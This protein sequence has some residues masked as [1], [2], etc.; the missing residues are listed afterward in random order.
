MNN[1][2][3]VVMGS[4]LLG[5]LEV[6]DRS[7]ATVARL[8]VGHWPVTVGRALSADLV[9]DDG[10]IAAEHLRIDAP[11]AGHIVVD[12]LDT[13]NG[14]RHGKLWHPRGAQFDWNGDDE[15]SLGRLR[16]RLR[17]PDMPIAAEQALPQSPWKI[18]GVTVALL[19]AV[20]GL[21]LVQAWF[22]ATDT[23]KF[24]QT[25]IGLPS[26]V[27]AALGVWAGMWALATKLFTGH[28]QFWRHVR[29]AATFSLIEPLVS[30]SGYLLAFMFSLESLAR[31]NF[32]LSG[33]VLATGVFMHLVVISPQ[34]R[35]ALMAIM[36]AITILGIVAT[37]GSNWLQ[38]KRATN[39][40]YMAA[41][42]PPSWRV[43]STVPV[44]QF[45]HE[46]NS[47]RSRL[48]ERLQDH[49][50]TGAVDAE[51]EDEGG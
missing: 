25:A 34:R 36:T 24:A 27:L 19:L 2:V 9:L 35:R 15:L 12:V 22:E 17:L 41:L 11:Q 43:A 44:A 28:P 3:S 16:L 38:N 13:I 46:A 32:L 30:V 7:G 37:V 40:L 39:Q 45:M 29:I 49:D 6:F 1:D 48:D 20:F 8:P 5:L 51:D 33:P 23:S 18:I 4:K 50:D 10:H 26:M 31:F 21:N 42:F 47:I 14:V